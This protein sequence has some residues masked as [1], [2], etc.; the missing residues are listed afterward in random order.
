MTVFG[1][2]GATA[3]ASAVIVTA[4]VL[5]GCF[6][7]DA[8]VAP[9]PSAAPSAAASGAPGAVDECDY[10]PGDPVAEMPSE[11]ADPASS[12]RPSFTPPP[13]VMVDS[14]RMSE[15]L[16]VLDSL[17]ALVPDAYVDPT[18][19]G[20]DWAEITARYRA[21]VEAGVSEDDFRVMLNRMVG[22]LGDEHSYVE[23]PEDVREADALYDAELDYVGIG[24]YIEAVPEEERAVI[25]VVVP[26]G[27]ADRAGLRAHDAVL[28]AD[29]EPIVDTKGFLPEERILGPEGTEVTLTIQRPG[30]T[31]RDVPVVRGRVSGGLPIRTCVVPG[32]EVGY[33]LLPCLCDGTIPERVG[34][35]LE[36]MDE[37]GVTSLVLDNRINSGGYYDPLVEILAFFADGELGEFA[38]RDERAEPLTVDGHDVGGSQQMPLAVLVDST[39]VSFGEVM[40]G[41]LQASDGATVVGGTT[42][43]NVEVLWAYELEHGWRAWIAHQVFDPAD[44]TYGPWEETGIV[45]EVVVPTR[46]DLFTEADDPGL[47]AA[48][49]AL[50]VSP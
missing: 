15:Q 9:S 45:P 33:I 17:A 2:T 14:Q 29:G 36:D 37:A 3:V 39:T 47:A 30:E 44:D 27:P 19:N 20:R 21:V 23:S 34:A 12:P 31:A 16:A 22:E 1:C 42:A 25:L 48:V 6:G 32:T 18:L 8:P 40:S 13:S 50:L 35:A 26:G 46:W 41:V 24:V 10:A 38:G 43:G 49:D 11:V 7:G 5:V 28:A 4:V